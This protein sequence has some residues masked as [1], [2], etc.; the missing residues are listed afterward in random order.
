M[1]YTDPSDIDALNEQIKQQAEAEEAERREQ[2]QEQLAELAR[3]AVKKPEE[4]STADL[5]SASDLSM[6]DFGKDK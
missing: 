1:S 2:E 5:I 6:L 3:R 4:S